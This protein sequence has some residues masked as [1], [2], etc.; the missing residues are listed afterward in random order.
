VEETIKSE[1]TTVLHYEPFELG[2]GVTVD[3]SSGQYDNGFLACARTGWSNPKLDSTFVQAAANL[4]SYANI[5]EKGTSPKNLSNL[6][7]VGHGTAGLISTGDGLSP[8]TTQGYIS[9]SNYTSWATAFSTIR[10]HGQLLT[11]CGCDCGAN[12]VGAQFL[13]QLATLLNMPVRGRTGLVFLS[14]PG[15]YISYENG[16][17][18]QVAQPGVM[19]NPIPQPIIA[20]AAAPLTQIWLKATGMVAIESVES[21]LLTTVNGKQQTVS[22]EQAHSLLGWTNL[23]KPVEIDAS[24]SAIMTAKMTIRGN[25]SGRGFQGELLVYNDRLLQHADDLKTFNWCSPA[26]TQALG[27]LR[28]SS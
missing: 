7:L 12:Q 23:D 22:S 15:A 1:F 21:I 28:L 26:F 9:A 11:L 16:S 13:F 24:P 2:G 3:N 19:P 17:V 20:V 10:G 8:R 4:S 6:V 25:R 18:W 14:C 27:H 5:A